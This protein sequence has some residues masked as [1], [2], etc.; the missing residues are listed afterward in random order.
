MHSVTLVLVLSLS[1]ALLPIGTIAGSLEGN[2]EIQEKNPRWSKVDGSKQSAYETADSVYFEI[3]EIP[4]SVLLDNTTQPSL[5]NGTIAWHDGTSAGDLFFWDGQTTSVVADS[6]FGGQISLYDGTIAYQRAAGVNNGVR[7]YY[8]DG[9]TNTNISGD[10]HA[11][12]LSQYNGNI[13]FS[14]YDGVSR[15]RFIL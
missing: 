9:N 11:G 10:L 4:N 15:S 8:W 1:S 13:A 7:V 14:G 6:C 3:V 2:P 5:Y 12:W